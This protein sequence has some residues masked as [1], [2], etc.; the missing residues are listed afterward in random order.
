MLFAQFPS[1]FF[2]LFI[3]DEITFVVGVLNQS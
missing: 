2:G 3:F 1:L